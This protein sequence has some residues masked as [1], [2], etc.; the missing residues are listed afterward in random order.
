M[1]KTYNEARLEGRCENCDR[2]PVLCR[3]EEKC[4]SDRKIYELVINLNQ[5]SIRFESTNKDRFNEILKQLEDA[6]LQCHSCITIDNYTI[7]V[8]FI[9]YWRTEEYYG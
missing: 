2:D 7:R 5:G 8:P 9:T 6:I 1:N 3:E 4:L